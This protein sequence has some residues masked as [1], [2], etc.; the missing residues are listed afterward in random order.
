[1]RITYPVYTV[2]VFAGAPSALGL[3]ESYRVH[4]DGTPT[5]LEQARRMARGATSRTRTDW[6][7]GR[8]FVPPCASIFEDSPS[9]G[10]GRH[11]GEY[12]S[13]ARKAFLRGVAQ[14]RYTAR[15]Q[16]ATDCT[17]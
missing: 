11:V 15:I 8:A 16:A 14:G 6:S 17:R 12:E 4:F 3:T 2:I 10:L 13:R 9:R 5:G 7:T 1:M